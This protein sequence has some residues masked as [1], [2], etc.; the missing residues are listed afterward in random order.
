MWSKTP[1]SASVAP[2]AVRFENLGGGVVTQTALAAAV[3]Y[4]KPIG[5]VPNRAT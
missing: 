1:G 4:N 2:T 5:D 3:A